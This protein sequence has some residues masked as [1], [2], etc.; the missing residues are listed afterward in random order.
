MPYKPNEYSKYA[1]SF[2][3]QN[4]MYKYEYLSVVLLAQKLHSYIGIN[5]LL[6]GRKIFSFL[7]D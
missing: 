7:V 5:I 2:K 1:L 4:I 6:A 3:K